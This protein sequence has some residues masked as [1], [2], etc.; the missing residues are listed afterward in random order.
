MQENQPIER[1]AGNCPL[2]HRLDITHRVIVGRFERRVCRQCADSY[3]RTVGVM[4]EPLAKIV[5]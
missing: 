3:K 1:V 5:S 2:C 4:V